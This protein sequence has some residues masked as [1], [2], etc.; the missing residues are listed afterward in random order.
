MLKLNTP[1]GLSVSVPETEIEDVSEKYSISEL[2]DAKA[3][4]ESNGYVVFKNVIPSV[5]CDE[6]MRLWEL[7]VKSSTKYL[8]R[9]ATAKAETNKFNNSGWVMN[10]ILNL[11]SLNPKYFKQLRT[12]T[13]ERI[14]TSESLVSILKFIINDAPK[15]VQSMYFEGNSATWEHQDSYYLD[16]ENIG[17]MV[18]CW[19]ALEDI[20]AAAGRF[21][22]CPGSHKL[23]LGLQN[24]ET[25][26]ADNHD[27]YIN[28]V[29]EEIKRQKLEI[30]PPKLDKG[31]LLLWNSWTI[32]GSLNSQDQKRS[33]SSI[34]CHVIP[35]SDKFLQLQSRSWMPETDDLNGVKVWRPKDQA[36]I[37]NKVA[38]SI[39]SNF[40]TIFHW[41]KRAAVKQLI[42]NAS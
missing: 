1:H 15:I 38:M 32:H 9:Q 27:V 22:V 34:T 23:N 8:Y 36:K 12:H 26:I 21:F 33:R 4:Y 3:Y 20:T 41:I 37:K 7:E 5:D 29:V 39:E 14:L 17:K 13:V 24:I 31:D 10:P 18:A 2:E 19:I 30:R 25:N 35:A 6:A 16:S 11:Q 42:R 28:S 40:P